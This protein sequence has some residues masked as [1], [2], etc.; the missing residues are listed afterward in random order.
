MQIESTVRFGGGTTIPRSIMS[1]RMKDTGGKRVL[2]AVN[3][4]DKPTSATFDVAGLEA[5]AATVAGTVFG[6]KQSR[7]RF[8]TPS[9]FPGHRHSRGNL[10]RRH[11]GGEG[12]MRSLWAVLTLF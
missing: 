11:E 3:R 12:L 6:Q 7:K 1:F 8:P 10:G 9:H 4:D 2:L 5:R